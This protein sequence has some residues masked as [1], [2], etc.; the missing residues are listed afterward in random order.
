MRLPAA[1]CLPP[2]SLL[3]RSAPKCKPILRRLK[4]ALVPRQRL[5]HLPSTLLPRRALLAPLL[6]GSRRRL[7]R[8]LPQSPLS[9]RRARKL[10]TFSCCRCLSLRPRLCPPLYQRQRRWFQARRAVRRISTCSLPLRRHSPSQMRGLQRATPV[11]PL[12]TRQRRTCSPR[13]IFRATTRLRLRL[14]LS[15]AWLPGGMAPRCTALLLAGLNSSPHFSRPRRLLLR[16]APLCMF[17]L[18]AGL[19]SSPLSPRPRRLPLIRAL[20]DEAEASTL[21]NRR[22][23]NRYPQAPGSPRIFRL[24]RRLWTIQA[25]PTLR[26]A[27][28]PPPLSQTVRAS[29]SWPLTALLLFRV[30]IPC[31]AVG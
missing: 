7:P 21:I 18:L 29:H 1:A 20:P 24:L 17:L 30:I 12:G 14:A 22:T 13:P 27:T 4:P 10:V 2:R 9:R 8:M 15:E 16:L 11:R 5:A 28:L 23:R 3:V 31:T 6:H 26:P 19:N 25:Q